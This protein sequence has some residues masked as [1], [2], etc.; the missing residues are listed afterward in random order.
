MISAPR[1]TTLDNIK[2]IIKQGARIPYLS[3]SAGGTQVQFIQAALELEVTPH[4]TS[5]GS[6]FMELKVENNRAD[7]ANVVQGQP[8]IQ[9]K[10][11]ETQLLVA[12]GDTTVIGGVF[13]TEEAESIGRVPLLGKIPVLGALFR[14]NSRTINRNEML[15][16]VTP[17][18]V[19]MPEKN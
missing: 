4:I 16:F 1:V 14:N 8:S 9:I 19:T 17:H 7:F 13:A 11:A 15:V 18:I 5:D 3:V 6:I 10:E 12:N 2:A